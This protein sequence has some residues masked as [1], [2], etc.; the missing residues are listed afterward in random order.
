MTNNEWLESLKPGDEVAV[1]NRGG[2]GYYGIY[3]V[4]RTTRTLIFVS[5]LGTEHAFKKLDGRERSIWGEKYIEQVTPEIR[6]R[7]RRMALIFIILCKENVFRLPT[8]KLEKIYEII[9]DEQN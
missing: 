9:K 5:V 6:E 7:S 3:K 1:T 8:D 2:D 4:T